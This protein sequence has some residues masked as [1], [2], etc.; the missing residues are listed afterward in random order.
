MYAKILLTVGAFV[1]SMA[2][3]SSVEIPKK[4]ATQSELAVMA[5]RVFDVSMA[6]ENE[7]VSHFA[8]KFCHAGADSAIVSRKRGLGSSS[9]EL[10]D[11]QPAAPGEQVH[12]NNRYNSRFLN[13][14]FHR[15]FHYS[16]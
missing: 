1:V 14:A 4:N 6:L 16:T 8:D 3:Y 5:A 12:H 7:V 11:K 15:H 13:Q 10:L 9:R 2:S